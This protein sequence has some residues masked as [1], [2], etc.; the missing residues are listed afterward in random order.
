[1]FQFQRSST[2]TVKKMKERGEE[3][4]KNQSPSQGDKEEAL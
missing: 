2:K 4:V 3:K 1:M